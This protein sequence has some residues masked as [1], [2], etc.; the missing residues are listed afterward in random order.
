MNDWTADPTV[1]GVLRRQVAFTPDS[2]GRF[3]ELWRESWTSGL[4]LKFRQANLSRSRAGVLRG[5]HF[6]RRQTDFWAVLEGTAHVAVVD[7]RERMRD[8]N[9]DERPRHSIH[10]IE[11]GGAIVIPPGVAH[12]FWAL[13]DVSLLYL[14]TEEY[15]GSDE[16]GFAWNDALAGVSWPAG[17][18]VL[19]ERDAKAPSMSSAVS[20]AR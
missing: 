15:D 7:L 20:R 4:G 12:G 5:L 10:V 6:H 11:A 14:V 2:R 1:G 18:P 3:G 8:L 9:F 19:S 17:A 13:D 16:Y